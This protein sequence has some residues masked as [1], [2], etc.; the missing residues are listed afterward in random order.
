MS[1]PM[2]NAECRKALRVL[3]ECVYKTRHDGVFESRMID[4]AEHVLSQRSMRD[5]LEWAEEI[6]GNKPEGGGGG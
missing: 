2:T 4:V 1:E 3:A 5:S 6:L